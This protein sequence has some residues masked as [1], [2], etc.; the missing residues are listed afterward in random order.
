MYIISLFAE[1]M[2]STD[3]NSEFKQIKKKWKNGIGPANSEASK[4]LVTERLSLSNGAETPVVHLLSVELNAVL[5]E[6]EP[7]LNYRCQLP[8]PPTLLAYSIY[9]YT[10]I[11]IK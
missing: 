7:L 8:N 9:T 11:F 4:E 1:K 2:T 5:R 6:L 10:Y 3:M